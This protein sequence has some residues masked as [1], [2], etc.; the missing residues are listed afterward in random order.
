MA[1]ITQAVD[2]DDGSRVLG[3]GGEDQGGKPTDGAHLGNGTRVR[4][5]P[6]YL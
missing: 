4:W 1:G 6:G 3:G 2:E 5:G